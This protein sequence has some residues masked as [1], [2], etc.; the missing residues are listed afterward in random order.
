MYVQLTGKDRVNLPKCTVIETNADSDR[1]LKSVMIQQNNT[2]QYYYSF[3]A[4]NN[5]NII[6]V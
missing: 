3:S 1:W 5:T 6:I 4:M 2:Q